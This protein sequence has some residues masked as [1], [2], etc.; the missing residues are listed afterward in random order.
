MPTRAFM[1]AE[2]VGNAQPTTSAIRSV[3]SEDLASLASLMYRAYIGTVDYDGE[4]PEQ[5]EEEMR[6]TFEGEYGPFDPEC[7]TLIEREGQVLSATLIT[8][9]Q[10]RPFV[11]FS[12]TDPSVRDQ[13]LARSCMLAAMAALRSR[14]ETELRLVVTLANAPAVALYSKLGFEIEV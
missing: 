6:K 4:T 1:R 13:G 7:S 9:F 3:T 11:A 10:G 12:M 5:S 14:H 2:L 8:R